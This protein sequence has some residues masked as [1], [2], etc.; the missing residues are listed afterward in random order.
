MTTPITC[1]TYIPATVAITVS[2]ELSETELIALANEWL[3]DHGNDDCETTIACR[4][5]L[6]DR[7]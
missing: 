7:E 5:Y 3:Y 2:E 6:E 4:K 1:S